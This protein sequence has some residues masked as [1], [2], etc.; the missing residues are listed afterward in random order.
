ME[1]E[2]TRV[3]L[4]S[5]NPYLLHLAEDLRS[6]LEEQGFSVEMERPVEVRSGTIFNLEWVLQFVMENLAWEASGGLLLTQTALWWKRRRKPGQGPSKVT[7][8]C[9]DEAGTLRERL[10][11]ERET[12]ED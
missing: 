1:G 3:V 8:E 4:T 12:E 10:T 6:D 2:G 5:P 11:I 9:F 7:L